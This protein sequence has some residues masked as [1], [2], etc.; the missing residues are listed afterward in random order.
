MA[1]T[2]SGTT[3]TTINKSLSGSLAFGVPQ[4][5]T[6]MLTGALGFGYIT[7]PK[8]LSGGLS[9][10]GNVAGVLSFGIVLT[11]AL[12]FAGTIR[13]SISALLG[14]ALSFVGT[15]WGEKAAQIMYMVSQLSFS[16][17]LSATLPFF[18]QA[19]SAGLSFAGQ[20][21]KATRQSLG[22]A[23]GLG[24]AF[25]AGGVTVFDLG[26]NA[27]LNF[28]GAVN[29]AVLRRLTAGLLTSGNVM[30]G[31]TRVLTG[32][33]VGFSGAIQRSY[34]VLLS[35]ALGLGAQLSRSTQVRLL[36]GLSPTGMIARRVTRA[37]QAVVSL[38]GHTTPLYINSHLFQANLAASLSFSGSSLPTL[39]T[40]ILYIVTT[41]A[42]IWRR[43][44][45]G[46]VEIEQDQYTVIDRS[47]NT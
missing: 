4:T 31:T 41:I 43:D 34:P 6:Q 7:H 45:Q 2:F 9:F 22:G 39:G 47:D 32:A 42:Q 26:F 3:G 30:R 13:R 27:A 33:G 23:L 17:G 8:S 40:L 10:T 29:R 14:G 35:A 5:F 38:S 21:S 24:G 36:A 25:L 16:G 44:N 20:A 15:W 46:L 37:L 12:T 11:A 28:T 18:T 19:L 1:L